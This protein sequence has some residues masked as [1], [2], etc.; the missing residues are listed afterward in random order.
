MADYQD[1]IADD[2]ARFI[3]SDAWR[4]IKYRILKYQEAQ[5][6][7]ANIHVRSNDNNEASHCLGTIDGAKM[8]LEI[9]ERLTG[10]IKKRKLD[11]DAALSVIENKQREEES[12]GSGKR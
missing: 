9:T 6:A 5:Q 4:L 8:S 1:K 2:I 7:K 10:E 12:Y 11:V 3:Q